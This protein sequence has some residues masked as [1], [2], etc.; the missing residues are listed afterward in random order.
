MLAHGAVLCGIH[1]FLPLGA[2]V[3]FSLT[4]NV[5]LISFFCYLIY[6]VE[7]PSELFRNSKMNIYC[8]LSYLRLDGKYH[9]WSVV[10]H[11]T[12]A[13]FFPPSSHVPLGGRDTWLCSHICNDP[14]LPNTLG[15]GSVLSYHLGP[16]TSFVL[17]Q[18]L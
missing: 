18:I 8:L 10:I 1:C 17:E 9:C 16:V 11:S 4:E 3:F 2:A 6:L 14:L 12:K 5:E 13:N 15:L 7:H